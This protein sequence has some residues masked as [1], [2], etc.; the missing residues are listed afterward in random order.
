MLISK[1]TGARPE[2]L[3]KLR[4]KDIEYED[5]VRFSKTARRERIQEY[6]Q[7][8]FPLMKITLKS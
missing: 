3:L 7:G 2:D 6:Q 4:W 5:V 1:N 8:V